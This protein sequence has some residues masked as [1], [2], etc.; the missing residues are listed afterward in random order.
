MVP[1]AFGVE[2]VGEHNVRDASQLPY[3]LTGQRGLLS[4][5]VVLGA[6]GS[7]VV[8]VVAAVIPQ[9]PINDVVGVDGR[10]SAHDAAPVVTL[11]DGGAKLVS[12]QRFHRSL[13]S[14]FDVLFQTETAFCGV[15]QQ[16]HPV[17]LA[18][19]EIH[20]VLDHD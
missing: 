20:P 5:Q 1:V 6:K 7:A 10:L 4:S 17:L 3:R 13:L 9:G 2:D 16:E 15:H 19:L 12:A 14:A 18:G 8:E 11:E